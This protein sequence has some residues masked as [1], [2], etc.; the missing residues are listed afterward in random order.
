[1]ADN[2]IVGQEYKLVPDKKGDLDG[3]HIFKGGDWKKI[4]NWVKPDTIAATAFKAGNFISGAGRYDPTIPEIGAAPEYNEMSKRAA[5]ASLGVLSSPDTQTSLNI[6]QQQFPESKAS[7]DQYGNPTVIMGGKPYYINRPG[8]T[9]RDVAE[10]AFDIGS[11]LGINK[12]IPG[13]M[14]GSIGGNALR[15]GTTGTA[16]SAEQDV[17]ANQTGGQNQGMNLPVNDVPILSGVNAIDPFKA[18]TT[19]ATTAVFQAGG[20]ALFAAIPSI[21]NAVRSTMTKLNMG[22]DAVFKNGKLTD[23]G[24]QALKQIGI[25]WNTMTT[26]FKARLAGQFSPNKLPPSNIDDAVR[27]AEAQSL[28]VPVPQTRGTISGNPRDQLLE[29]FA[30]KGV[31]GTHA[32]E[33]VAGSRQA[34]QGALDENVTAIQ[35]II[36]ERS[37]PPGATPNI[38]TKG[39][40]G[41]AAQVELAA[42][43]AAA[44]IKARAKYKKT[45]DLADSTGATIPP[46]VFK[47]FGES[48]RANVTRSH[49]LDDLPVVTQMLDRVT[50]LGT[51]KGNVSISDLFRLR[52]QV[53]SKASSNF[54]NETGV[55]LKTIKTQLDDRIEALADTALLKGEGELIKSWTSAIKNYKDFAKTWKSNNLVDRLTRTNRN[56]NTELA[57]APEDA[58]RYIFNTNG[59]GFLSKANLQRDL[60]K[61]KK[62]L[63]PDAWNG[64]RQEVYLRIV[65]SG[66]NAQ[67][68]SGNKLLTATTKAFDD[69]API[70]S[71]LYNAEEKALLQQFAK[72]AQRTTGGASNTSNTAIAQATMLKD[73]SNRLIAVLGV[74]EGNK[75]IAA[76]PMARNIGDRFRASQLKNAVD[77]RP[78]VVLPNVGAAPGALGLI[79]N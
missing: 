50:K 74:K 10:T 25:E 14:S 73:M 13:S 69:N 26:E 48:V 21:V 24:E 27:Y 49:A 38:I 31:Y 76:F 68:L 6:I 9:G 45:E 53:T 42:Q 1:M 5:M 39:G 43:R 64:I 4:D 34:A 20:D 54:G 57:V 16:L 59:M 7:Q 17:I 11:F 22:D 51:Q 35:K 15:A 19:G 33:I 58:A 28:P 67:G 66:K 55:A 37:L 12:M 18:L 71:A 60:L 63:T 70:M 29:D 3:P 75:Y 36:A 8:F 47:G 23:V 40:G 41:E 52:Q 77:A 46:T 56:D 61:M 78:D 72:V 79:G 65:Q 30:S 32:Q 44:Q 62:L 2:F